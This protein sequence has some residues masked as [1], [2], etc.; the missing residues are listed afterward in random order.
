LR[1]WL[2]KVYLQANWAWYSESVW[3]T[4]SNNLHFIKNYFPSKSDPYSPWGIFYWIF[5]WAPLRVGFWG[6]IIFD[7]M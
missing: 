4:A 1:F 5:R 6:K 2:Q 3:K 7:E